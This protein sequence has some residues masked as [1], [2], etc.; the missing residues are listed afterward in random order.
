MDTLLVYSGCI[1]IVMI[2]IIYIGVIVLMCYYKN[3]EGDEY[4]NG[5]ERSIVTHK[6]LG[7]RGDMGNQIFQLA[8]IIAAGER[9]DAKII[10]PKTIDELPIN[11]LFDLKR[12]EIRDI[13]TDM[14]Y[15]EYD[16]YENIIIPKDGRRYDIRGYRQAYKY[17]DEMR[18]EICKIFTPKNEII[19]EVKKNIPNEYIAVHIRKGDY[20]KLIH[21]IPLLREFRRC[22]MEYYKK[23]INKLRET[24]PDCQLI[25]CTDSPEWVT[26]LLGEL[27]SKAILSPI[28]E[29]ISPKFIDFCVLY[30]ADAVVMSNSTYSWW[31]CY[32][33][34]G[35]QIISPTPW[36]D[37]D[38]FIGTALGLDGPYLQYPEW[39]LLDADN[40]KVVRE[41]H[42]KNKEDTN[43]DTL[44]VYKFAR[45]MLI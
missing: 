12:F 4:E 16:N 8:C 26:P 23:G 18:E 20:I 41:P 32:L 34:G 30:L 11:K 43:G 24:Y 27:D 2:I 36:W 5:E 40:G 10:L 1:I 45:V 14:T 13:N 25:V 37:P 42:G 22:Q 21:N 6:T 44:S 38:G 31:A 35:R 19:D 33:R 17:F 28:I 3:P 9:S 39:W 29:N 7:R 15:Y